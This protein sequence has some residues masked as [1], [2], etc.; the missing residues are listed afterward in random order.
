MP[1][2]QGGR[3]RPAP[4]RSAQNRADRGNRPARGARP[5]DPARSAAYAVV[6][7]VHADGAY[8]NLAL[9]AALERHDL[10]G[11]DAAFAT[12]LAAGTIRRRGTY[13]AVLA[14]CLDRPL[15]RVDPPVLDAL[16][17]GTHQL[18]SMR[19]PP[20]AAVGTTVD[21]VRSQIHRGAA[22]FANAVLR[23]VGARDLD[24]WLTVVAPDPATDPLGHAEIV[25][26]H[27]RWVVEEL[28]RALDHAG[29]AGE[30]G[31]LLAA[32]NVAPKVTLVA[33]PGLCDLPEL[34]AAGATPT[35]RTP[36][37]AVLDA[38][39]PG[40]I[41]AVR[42][43]RAGVQDEGSQLVTL[44]LADAPVEGRDERWLDMCAGPGG[45]AA[46]LGALARRRGAHL[47]ANEL[48]A[49][50]ATLVRRTVRALGDAVTVQ[51]GDATAPSWE[52]AAYDR[53]LLD[54]PCTGLGA[55]RRR[56]EA[57]WRRTPDDLADLTRLQ[58]RLLEVAADSVR[59]GGIVAYVTCSPVV[60]ETTE[61]VEA[62]LA[63]RDDLRLEHT[64]QLWP[65]VD[66]TDAMYLALLRRS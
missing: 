54:A 7:A 25:H 6:R 20:H 21:L 33:R 36:Y 53:V 57:R 17:L 64:E 27:P 23:K 55:L 11:R 2:Q 39:D 41:P 49:H 58:R 1:E 47:L 37:A 18:L 40:S 10:T 59:P 9:P 29:R 14:A 15:D 12:E 44:A 13:D 66:S 62:V 22:G 4:K 48:Q 63:D 16:R 51:T 24:S 26:A 34:E 65:H 31:D 30:L 56:A 8:T 3:N 28:A 42:E 43:G 19:V 35:G 46:L 60:A 32:D 52:Q 61:V 38:G 50:R 45:K 5:V